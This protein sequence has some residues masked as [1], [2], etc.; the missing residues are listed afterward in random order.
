MHRLKS[1]KLYF[2]SVLK[3]FF[4]SF[5]NYYFK[6]NFY[7]KKLVTLIPTRIFYSP[8]SYLAASLISTS[9]DFYEIT[10]ISPELLWK[11]D[12]KNKLKFENLHSFLWLT[13]IDRKKG[14]I[15]TKN[16]ISSWIDNFYNYEPRVWNIEITSKRI[17]SWT[18]N[19][20]I[21][22]ED[23][24]KTYKEKFLKSLV[25]QSNFLIK[26]Q[27]SLPYD[28]S[29]IICCAAIILSGIIF[30][31]TELNFKFGIRELE[32]IVN[33]Y[34]DKSGF[35]KT[36]NPEEVF[37]CIKYLILIR[38]WLREAQISVPEFLNEIILKCG[39]CYSFLSTAHKKSPLFNGATEIDYKD[40]DNF[41]KTLKYKFNNEDFQI[42]D[43]IKIKKKSLYFLWIVAILLQTTLLEITKLVAYQ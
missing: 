26:N 40:Y 37:I 19:T 39:N 17:I 3:L 20:D 1:I 22:L 24:N 7:N 13:K 28:P 27:A 30:Q 15:F 12:S 8:S 43:L 23:S 18:S 2:F 34:F 10:N 16:I 5:R 41:L 21:T 32:K 11:T 33:I 42:S 4:L 31:E 6:S 14:K 38:E 25:K 36:R 9:S 35:P 29:K